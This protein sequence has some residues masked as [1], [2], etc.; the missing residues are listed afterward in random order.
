MVCA[1]NHIILLIKNEIHNT[2]VCF[3]GKKYYQ[4]Q[5]ISVIIKALRSGNKKTKTLQ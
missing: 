5:S 4:I 3:F 1:S 2:R